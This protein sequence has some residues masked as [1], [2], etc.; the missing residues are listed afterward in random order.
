MFFKGTSVDVLCGRWQIAFMLFV[1]DGPLPAASYDVHERPVAATCQ[2]F[3]SKETGDLKLTTVFK[4]ASAGVLCGL[5][6]ANI[7]VVQG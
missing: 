1:G 7:F 2:L 4:G 5:L 6:P 3:Y